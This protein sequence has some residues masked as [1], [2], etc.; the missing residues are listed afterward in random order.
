MVGGE[1]LR[2]FVAPEI[3]FGEG[4]LDLSGRF[5]RNLGGRRI[6]V[7][8]DPGV[9]AAGWT[10]KVHKSLEEEHLSVVVYGKVRPNPSTASVMEGASVFVR[11]QCD[12]LLAVGGGSPIDCAKA[13]G[14]VV[15]NEQHVLEFEGVD[16]VS[17]PPPPLVCVPTTAGSAADVSQFAI[18]TDEVRKV[19]FAIISKTMVPDVA[20][21]DPR[22]TVTMEK[23]LTVATGMDVLTHAVEAYVSNASSPLTDL[24]ALEAVRL[25]A[26]HLPGAAAGLDNLEH[27]RGMMLASLYAGLAFS[28]AGLGMVH[29]LA[30]SLGGLLDLPHGECNALLLGHG[31]AANYSASPERFARILQAFKAEESMMPVSSVASTPPEKVLEELLAR[32]AAL[33]GISGIAV[34]LRDFGLSREDIPRIARFAYQDPC[35]LTNPRHLDAAE[36]EEVLHGAW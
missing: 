15:S 21:I 29:A 8:S 1:S 31:C 19:K 30:H 36:L 32:I 6:L 2:K 3:V 20:L 26:R 10:E 18:I 34:R 35:L 7:V 5:A 27:R 14:A 17:L 11:E 24:H 33:G 4:A 12:M 28:N 22:T 25:V 9:I 13:I 23:E 16:N